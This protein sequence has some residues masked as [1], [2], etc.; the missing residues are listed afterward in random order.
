MKRREAMNKA[1]QEI[2]NSLL[3]QNAIIQKKYNLLF[4]NYQNN[5]RVIEKIREYYRTQRDTNIQ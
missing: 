4:K 5:L 2:I 1:G 3:K